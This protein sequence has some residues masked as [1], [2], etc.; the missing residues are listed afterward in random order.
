MTEEEAQEWRERLQ[1]AVAET[2]RKRAE[3]K[4]FRAD[5]L[6][7]RKYGKAAYHR[8]KLA[9]N[10][11]KENT[12]TDT[13][14]SKY[15]RLERIAASHGLHLQHVDAYQLITKMGAHIGSPKTLEDM[16]TTFTDAAVR[17]HQVL[18]EN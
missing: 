13:E 15:E 10:R 2:L 4:A 18:K 14:T 6:R 7:N 5:H 12:M 9:R 3:R 11:T 8:A 1:R 17:F 16:E